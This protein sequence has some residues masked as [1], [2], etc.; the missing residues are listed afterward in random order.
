MLNT[1][2]TGGTMTV[3][4]NLVVMVGM[5]VVV[6][7]G[8]RLVDGPVSIRRVWP[9]AGIAGGVSLW[10][11]RGPLAAC[12]AA[13]YLLV[14]LALAGS[15][16][17]RRKPVTPREIA[18]LTALV[19]PAIAGSALVAERAGYPLFGFK[20]EILALTV[21]H[22][23][24]AG[25]AAALVAGLVCRAAKDGPLAKVAALSVPAGTALVLAGYF[26]NDYAE[27]A[28]AVVL[29]VGMWSVGWLTWREVRTPD[30]L[31]RVLLVVSSAILVA[32]MLLALDWALGEA[33]GVPH[34]SLTWMAATHGVGNA[35]G[36][37]VCSI[38]A[39]RRLAAVGGADNQTTVGGAD[40]RTIVGGAD[41]RT[42]E[43]L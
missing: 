35:L 6:P 31:T 38:A 26:V 21:P 30:R 20:L 27:L 19:T 37:A 15:A 39:W 2:N 41:N 32:T 22:F 7:V 28:G 24:F 4:V 43:A 11:D 34:L 42:L 40:N 33:F 3:L 25:F 10:L 23:H 13:G 36:F 14:T 9:L 18:V 29:T 8:L 16:P 12:L 5:L 17:L 1:F